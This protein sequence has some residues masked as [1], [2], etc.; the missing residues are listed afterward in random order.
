M[1]D[2]SVI[3]FLENIIMEKGREK[4]R[5]KRQVQELDDEIRYYRQIL[6]KYKFNR[7]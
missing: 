4:A 6:K 3:V 5:K 7:N 2:N 1:V